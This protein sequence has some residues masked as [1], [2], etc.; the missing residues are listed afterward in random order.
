MTTGAV[1][2]ILDGFLFGEGPRWHD[3]ELWFSD[4]Q[5]RTVRRTTVEGDATI[6]SE[7]PDDEPSGLGWLPDGRLLVVAMETQRRLRI[8]LADPAHG[9]GLEDHAQIVELVE[10]LEV[11]LAHLPT[12]A[13]ADDDVPFAFQP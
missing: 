12:A 9:R 11:E 3:G 6:V 10:N 7:I 13:R 2:T 1:R 8:E 4:V 5:G